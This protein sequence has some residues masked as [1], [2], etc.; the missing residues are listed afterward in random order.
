MIKPVAP[1][2]APETQAALDKWMGG[3]PMEPLALFR[4]LLRHPRLADKMRPLGSLLLARLGLPP[5]GIARAVRARRLLSPDL[6]RGE[7][8]AG[9]AR[10][11]GGAVYWQVALSERNAGL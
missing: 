6:V 7:C 9:G 4:V 10:A 8:G 1:P 3:A 2:Y 11:V 5:R